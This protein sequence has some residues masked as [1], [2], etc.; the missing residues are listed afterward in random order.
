M[1]RA[2]MKRALMKRAPAARARGVALLLVM[3]IIALLATLVAAFAFS[4]RIERL[5]A[6]SL[7]QEVVVGQ[8]ARAG[9]EYALTRVFENDPRLRW[10]PD[11]RP[12]PWAFGD[13][14]VEVS[15]VDESGKVDLNTADVPFLSQLFV[16]LGTDKQEADRLAAAIADW[17]D[18]DNLT[19]PQGGAEDPDYASAGL[20]YGAKDAPFD[21]IAE[22][23]QVLGMTPQL[24]AKVAPLLTVYSGQMRPDP[25]YAPAEVLQA[26]GVDAAPILARR[27]QTQPKPG[28]LDDSALL[29]GGTG[30]YSIVS[31]ARLRDG[32]QAVLKAVVRAGIGTVPGS[33]YLALR[34][35]E[36]AI[37]R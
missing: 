30:T 31:R 11:G 37:P 32:R 10:K 16:V 5:Q 23:E 20:P 25:N 35:E 36:G 8:A 3:W 2:L 13:A 9:L 18:I 28:D 26:L 19:Q 29:G 4:A 24:Y 27:K 14:Q 22:V 7:D 15:I 1:K 34:W 6:R 12:Y 17:R 21:T 33:A